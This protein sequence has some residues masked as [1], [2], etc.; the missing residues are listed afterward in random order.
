MSS[1]FCNRFLKPLII[2][3]KKPAKI[4]F[5]AN[6]KLQIIVI[7]MHKKLT[8]LEFYLIFLVLLFAYKFTLFI[9]SVFF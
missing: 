1:P 5:K 9:A 8:K 7:L 4:F 2:S 3:P 6:F